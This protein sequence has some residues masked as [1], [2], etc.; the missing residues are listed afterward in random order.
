MEEK[1]I[2][3]E[4]AK[5]VKEIGISHSSKYS[6][7]LIINDTYYEDHHKGDEYL[8]Y[9]SN[10]II[11]RTEP[12]FQ[13]SY[14][15]IGNAY[16]Q[17]GLQKLLRDEYKIHIEISYVDDVFG[18]QSTCTTII[19]NTEFFESGRCETY[20]DALEIGIVNALVKLRV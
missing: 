15:E 6:Y 10:E 18:Y 12:P 16:T 1:L 7:Y 17:S 9:K 11:C 19:D 5:L 2:T 14:I 3:I 13:T 4:T 8:A 20:E